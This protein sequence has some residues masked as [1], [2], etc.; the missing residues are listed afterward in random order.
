M[1]EVSVCAQGIPCM[2]DDSS[3]AR[4]LPGNLKCCRACPYRT[5]QLQAQKHAERK[6]VGMRKCMTSRAGW[7]Y[8]RA[9]RGPS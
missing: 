8:L 9:R 4:G 5:Q 1:D 2:D 7:K 6:P 3:R